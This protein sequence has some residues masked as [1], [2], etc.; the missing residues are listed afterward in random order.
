MHSQNV[1]P[2][3]TPQTVS[4]AFCTL[5]AASSAPYGYTLAMWSSGAL[6]LRSHGVPHVP[7]VFVFAAGA[8]GGFNLLG[9]LAR[10]TIEIMR[11]VIQPGDRLLAGLLD[12]I[13]VGAAV[14]AVSLLAEI[15]GWLPWLLAP[16]VA[17]VLYLLLAS[18]QLA[19]VELRSMLRE[20]RVD[21]SR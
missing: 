10:Q 13:A 7:E 17:T 14:G 2:P 6:L 21:A 8:I 5:L 20:N 12:W 18:L 11:P 15:H 1:A 4:A 16:F 19:A 9:L 3:S